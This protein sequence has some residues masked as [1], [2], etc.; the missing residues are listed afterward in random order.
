MKDA[1]YRTVS[2]IEVSEH[3]STVIVK[4]ETPLVIEFTMVLSTLTKYELTSVDNEGFTVM[5]LSIDEKVT[6]AGDGTRAYVI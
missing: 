2:V 6:N 1:G 3:C 5:L 4:V